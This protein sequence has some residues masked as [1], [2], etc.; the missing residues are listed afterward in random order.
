M[1]VAE[2]ALY[3]EQRAAQDAEVQDLDVALGIT[4][5]HLVETGEPGPV[6]CDVAARVGAEI[7]VIGSHGHGWFK[8]VLM[9]SVSTQ[10]L[11]SCHVPVL[12]VR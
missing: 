1:A 11:A 6:I 5:E 8:R 4:A 3:I 7:V 2:L 10:V 12:L 9:G